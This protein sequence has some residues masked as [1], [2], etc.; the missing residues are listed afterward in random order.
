ME[1]FSQNVA[2]IGLTFVTLLCVAGA[3]LLAW[4]GASVPDMLQV[5]GGASA[6]ALGAQLARDGSA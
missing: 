6:G 2:A 1:K 4:D 5:I 3:I